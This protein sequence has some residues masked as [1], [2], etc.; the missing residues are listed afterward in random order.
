MEKFEKILI[1][2]IIVVIVFIF[3]IFSFLIYSY[4]TKL[5]LNV[6]NHERRANGKYYVNV[7][8]KNNLNKDI[9]GS[10]VVELEQNNT[11]YSYGGIHTDAKPNPSNDH[12]Y[13]IISSGESIT[14]ELE[15]DVPLNHSPE[16]IRFYNWDNEQ[17]SYLI[18]CSANL[19]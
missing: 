9:K 13:L 19:E 4:T 10:F 12:L 18:E 3:S 11:H 15:F 5:E 17:L 2:S 14:K 6:I 7:T 1:I 8:L 16:S